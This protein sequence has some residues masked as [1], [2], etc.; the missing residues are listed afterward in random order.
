MF[1]LQK[2]RRVT[3]IDIVLISWCVPGQEVCGIEREVNAGL[4]E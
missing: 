2:K 1:A 4:Q 3:R